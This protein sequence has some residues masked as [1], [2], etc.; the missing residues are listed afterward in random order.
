MGTRGDFQPYAALARELT[1]AGATVVL[2]V[3]EG[4]EGMIEATG[5]RVRSLPIDYQ[6]LLQ[7]P[8]IKA[9][10]FSAAGAVKAAQKKTS[11]C[12]RR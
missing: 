6:A 7:T 12:R 11:S 8:E 4:F 2:V 1:L 3:G 10:L 9:A 5:A